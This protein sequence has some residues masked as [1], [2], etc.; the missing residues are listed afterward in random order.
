[1][2]FSVKM[3]KEVGSKFSAKLEKRRKRQRR[4]RRRRKKSIV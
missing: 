1:M 2:L 3:W 4:K